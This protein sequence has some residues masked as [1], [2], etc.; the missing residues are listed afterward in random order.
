[1]NKLDRHSTDSINDRTW[2]YLLA[3]YVLGFVVGHVLAKC[4]AGGE[5][6]GAFLGGL[7]VALSGRSLG[8]PWRTEDSKEDPK[9]PRGDGT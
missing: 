3:G 9:M 5:R 7:G 8:S 6:A 2:L 4:G 1:L